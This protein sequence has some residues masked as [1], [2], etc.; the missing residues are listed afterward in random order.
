[1]VFSLTAGLIVVLVWV[2]QFSV[3]FSGLFQQGDSTVS[4]NERGTMW[5]KFSAAV[6]TSVKQIKDTTSGAYEGL[7]TQ[8]E[9]TNELE[10]VPG[11]EEKT[12]EQ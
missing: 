6:S 8:I 2:F 3:T 7:K 1:M 5:S 11:Q 9:K 4:L 12:I 10:I